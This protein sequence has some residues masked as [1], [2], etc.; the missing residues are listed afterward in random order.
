MRRKEAEKQRLLEQKKIVVAPEVDSDSEL[1]ENLN[2][3]R[4]EGESAAT[5]D[6]AIRVLKGDEIGT[7]QVFHLQLKLNSFYRTDIQKNA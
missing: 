2:R 1:P 4:M 6:E 5:V 3:L 7:A